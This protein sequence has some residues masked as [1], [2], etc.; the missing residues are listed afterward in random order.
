MLDK[1]GEDGGIQQP[2]MAIYVSFLP[3]LNI[4]FNFE[5]LDEGVF[6]ALY[7]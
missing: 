1:K 5:Y 3:T 4:L 2:L 7:F 6:K